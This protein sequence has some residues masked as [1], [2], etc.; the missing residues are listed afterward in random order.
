MIGLDDLPERLPSV[1]AAEVERVATEA[2]REA[3]RP[4][5]NTDTVAQLRKVL[6]LAESGS[7]DGVAL[8]YTFSGDGAGFGTGW[9]FDRTC[10]LPALVGA[11]AVLS[12]RLAAALMRDQDD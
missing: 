4:R 7:I 6:A 12:A 9:D 5:P 3:A 2:L 11:G 1:D 10:D 8:A